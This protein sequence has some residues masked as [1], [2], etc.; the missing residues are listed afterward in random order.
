MLASDGNFQV[1]LKLQRPSNMY[2]YGYVISYTVAKSW[3]ITIG[4]QTFA[5]KFPR[6]WQSLFILFSLFLLSQP[7]SQSLID[8]LTCLIFMNIL[9]IS[10][11]LLIL[12]NVDPDLTA[13]SWSEIRWSIWMSPAA[14]Q[15]RDWR[16]NDFLVIVNR[17]ILM[18]ASELGL[19]ERR[20]QKHLEVRLSRSMN[21]QI[22]DAV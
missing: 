15:A 18:Q 22:S 1:I 5:N 2:Y 8:F 20:I 14:R 9:I 13:R 21:L 17:E 3:I 4:E 16:R 10:S 19:N 12:W 7:T 11:L 6:S